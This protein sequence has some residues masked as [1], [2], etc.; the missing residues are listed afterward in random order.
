MSVVSV[1]VGGPREI[2]WEG[3]RAMTSIY[4]TP[5]SGRVAVRRH[6]LDGDQQSDLTVHGGPD[7]AVYGYPLE[8]Y[9]YW[10]GELPD[11]ELPLG[12]FGENLTVTG[13]DEHALSIGDVLRIGSAELMVSQPRLPCFKLAA[14]FGR[15]DMVKRFLASRRVGF[16]FSIVTEGDVAAGDS[17]EWI[18]RASERMS[19]AEM[20]GL[21]ATKTPATAD[22]RRALGLR[23]LAD[24]W[25]EQIEQ[26]LA[27]R[28][29]NDRRA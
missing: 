8:H 21:Y 18:D 7:K 29:A 19:V 28:T 13:L 15:K 1:N 14:R 20:A 11:A 17:I 12:V 2:E 22:L 6:N 4:K 9:D 26:I 16:Y 23:G 24:V 10:R 25:R 5:V 3:K 27:S